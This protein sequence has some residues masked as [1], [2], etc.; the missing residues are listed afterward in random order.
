M[1][2]NLAAD[3]EHRIRDGE[4][5]DRA[6]LASH[7]RVILRHR[8]AKVPLAIWRD[9]QVLEIDPE[10]VELP[11]IDDLIAPQGGKR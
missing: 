10:L 1:N 5:I 8:Q 4:A 2:R 6:I 7:R 9:G 3:V 11:M